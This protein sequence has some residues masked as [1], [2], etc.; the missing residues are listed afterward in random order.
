MRGGAQAH[1]LACDDGWHYVTKFIDNPQHRRI[2]VNEWTAKAL[3]DQLGVA[4]P[5][6]RVVEVS[7][8]F[9]RAAPEVRYEFGTRRAVPCAG[10]H[11]GSAFPG[12]P[13][14]E[15]VYDFLPDSLLPSVANLAHFAGALVFDKWTANSDSRQAIFFRRRLREWLDVDA[16]AQQKGFIAQMVD[17][18]FIFDGPHWSYNDSPIQGLYFRPLAYAGIRTLDDF[19]PWLERARNCPEPLCDAILKQMPPEWLDGDEG[20]FEALLARLMRRRDRIEELLLATVRGRPQAFPDWR[21][22]PSAAG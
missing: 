19:Q 8:E 4:A 21:R 5:A 1:L 18:G 12:N 3:L 10:R 6:V 9:L 11:F 20:E 7:E 13:H 2:L 15:A 14:T 16:P 17:H 22:G